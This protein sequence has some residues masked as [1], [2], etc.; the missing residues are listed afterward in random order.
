MLIAH[1]YWRLEYGRLAAGI[2]IS[3]ESTQTT[4]GVQS[5]SPSR[6]VRSNELR[7]G[8]GPQTMSLDG[9]HL[10]RLVDTEWGDTSF[11]HERYGRQNFTELETPSGFVTSPSVLVGTTVALILLIEALDA[12]QRSVTSV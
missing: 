10:P 3:K 4:R 6:R 8:V 11:A 12:M 2:D 1:F 7:Y 9:A 5:S